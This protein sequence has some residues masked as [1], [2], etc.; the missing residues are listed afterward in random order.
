MPVIIAA[1][2]ASRIPMLSARVYR[3]ALLRI[4]YLTLSM[5]IEEGVKRKAARVFEC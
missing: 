1:G 2:T 4:N 5:N 3:E